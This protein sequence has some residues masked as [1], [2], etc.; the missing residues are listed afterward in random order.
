MI[1]HILS[2]THTSPTV[3]SYPFHT[4]TKLLPRV[5]V[6]LHTIGAAQMSISGGISP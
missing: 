2:Y 4:P 1:I 5:C 3:L 6:P